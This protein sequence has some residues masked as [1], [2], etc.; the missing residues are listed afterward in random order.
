MQLDLRREK[1]DERIEEE[2]SITPFLPLTPTI[3]IS[4]YDD[5]E[6]EVFD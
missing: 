5:G 1:F 4:D 2:S 3:D 6:D